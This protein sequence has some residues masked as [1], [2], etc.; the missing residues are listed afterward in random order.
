LK[1]F[2]EVIMPPSLEVNG[3]GLTSY[4]DFSTLTKQAHILFGNDLGTP[5]I[6]VAGS[7]NT[8][9]VRLT[10]LANPST[11]TDAVTKEYVDAAINGLHI[12]LPVRFAAQSAM[13]MATDLLV[14]ALFKS[15]DATS[16]L[17]LEDRVLLM[18]QYN[19]VENGIWEITAGA[20]MRPSDFASPM[21]AT[22]VYVFVDQGDLLDRAFVCITGAALSVVDANAL[23]WV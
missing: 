21:M 17:S 16:A 9:T 6:K 5:Y 20:P 10:N 22:G 2:C 3:L 19:A 14:G 23:T 13:E 8:D 11:M 4:S 12:K 15:G 1:T 7:T 18:N